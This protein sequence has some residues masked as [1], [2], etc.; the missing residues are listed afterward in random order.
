MKK[1]AAI[2]LL[3]VFCL[4][5]CQ[6]GRSPKGAD[7]FV[8]DTGESD[9]E[10][11]SAAKGD[12]EKMGEY[13]KITPEEAKEMMD[14]QTVTVVDVRTEEEYRT[15]HIPGAVLVPNEEISDRA[16]EILTDQ[17]A[18]ILV[19]CRSGRRSKQAA[20]ALLE[21]GYQN[22]YDFGGIIDWPYDK[23]ADS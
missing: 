5:G 4:T 18:V 21:L 3:A 23:M 20:K 11:M 12:E 22:V 2:L 17:D 10:G 16:L 15:E 14:T 6:A 9:R 7:N 8:S 1:A 13:R 19:Y